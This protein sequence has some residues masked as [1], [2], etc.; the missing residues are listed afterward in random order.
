[1]S[2]EAKRIKIA[3][4]SGASAGVGVEFIKQMDQRYPDLDEFWM[5]ARRRERMDELAATLNTKAC[6]FAADVTNDSD[7][8]SFW[9]ALETVNP[10]VRFLINNAGYGTTG[11]FET[12]GEDKALG[13]IDLNNRSLV[14]MSKRCLPY[15]TAGARIINLASVAAFLPQP[16]FA[17]YAASKSFTLSFSRALNAELKQRKISVTAVCPNPMNTEFFSIAGDK[18]ASKS[19][20]DIGVERVDHMVSTA[21][22]KAEKGRDLSTSCWQAKVIHFLSRILPHRFIL[23]VERKIGLFE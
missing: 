6:V 11:R 1:M 22:R 13:M 20:K 9:A 3:I 14:Q 19:I 18:P 17:V 10:D 5:L 21:L 12:V 15:M 4:V 23:F 16:D 7:M 8:E 2:A